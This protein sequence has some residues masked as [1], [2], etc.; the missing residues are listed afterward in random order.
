MSSNF[1]LSGADFS[2]WEALVKQLASGAKVS[3]T[4]ESS[5]GTNINT[6]P[7][8]VND[9]PSVSSTR[10]PPAV[11]EEN[12]ISSSVPWKGSTYIIR[13]S[14]TSQVLTLLDG[15]VVLEKPGGRGHIKWDCVENGGWL[16]FKN[17]ISGKYLGED[18][19]ELVCV[20]GYHKSPQHFVTRPVPNGGYLLLMRQDINWFFGSGETLRAI[21]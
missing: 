4:Q 2:R 5:T 19:G 10:T 15:Q 21:D 9:P 17:P 12:R 3:D 18:K 13:H 6:P 11:A 16:G 7:T 8:T 20:V 1:D 14:T